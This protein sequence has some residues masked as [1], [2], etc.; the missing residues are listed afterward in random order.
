MRCRDLTAMCGPTS[1]EAIGAFS[2][3]DVQE[4]MKAQAPHLYELLLATSLPPL[5]YRDTQKVKDADSGATYAMAMLLKHRSQRA[6]G[7]HCLCL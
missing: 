6:M 4:H 3:E 5:R 1:E 7:L 2:I